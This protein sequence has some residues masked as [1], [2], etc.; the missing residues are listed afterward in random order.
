M[1]KLPNHC[2]NGMKKNIF[3]KVN[4]QA[5]VAVVGANN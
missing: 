4:E 2:I 1:K 5:G 3:M